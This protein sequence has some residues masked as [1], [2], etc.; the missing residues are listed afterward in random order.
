VGNRAIP[1]LLA[2]VVLSI[3]LSGC[4]EPIAEKEQVDA[5]ILVQVEDPCS[6]PSEPITQSMTVISVSG[7]DR[8]FRLTV[9]SSD[10]GVKLALVIAFHG[11]GMADED[12]NQQDEFDQLA[13]QE[14]FIMAYAIA[15]DGRTE[16]EGEWYLNTAATS[17]DDNDFALTI[18][19]ELSK[20]YCVDQDRLYAIGYSLGSMFT[21]EVACQLNYKFA[22]VASFAGTMPVEPETCDLIGSMSVM[23]IHGKLDLIID[24]DDDWDWKDGEHEGVGTMSNIPGMIDYWAEKSNCQNVDSHYHQTVEHIV[25]SDCV[26][27]VIVEHHGLEFGGHTWPDDVAGTETYMLIWDF[28]SRFTN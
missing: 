9:P 15:E 18:V 8:L 14:K 19:N 21:Y 2:F 11:G 7:V 24:Y 4:T 3:P 28:L 27:G 5:E 13:E 1:I 17:R 20:S 26:G 22:A 6:L 16:S 10:P 25:H 12:F 23:H